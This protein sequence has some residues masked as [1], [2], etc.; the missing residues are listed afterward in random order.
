MFSIS[1]THIHSKVT[2][3]M[4]IAIR[5]H[6][7]VRFMCIPTI[8]ILI[9]DNRTTINTINRLKYKSESDISSYPINIVESNHGK[10]TENKML[11]IYVVRALATARVAIPLLAATALLT[12]SPILFPQQMTVRPISCSFIFK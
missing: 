9:N 7:N 3:Q 1:P 8:L 6:V 5:N 11:K 2:K 4:Y 10:P 12:M